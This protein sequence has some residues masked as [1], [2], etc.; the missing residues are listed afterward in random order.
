MKTKSLHLL[1]LKEDTSSHVKE[2]LKEIKKSERT[3]FYFH[4]G[5]TTKNYLKRLAPYLLQTM[6]SKAIL[7][8]KTHVVFIEYDTNPFDFRLL[9]DPFKN[10]FLK[11]LFKFIKEKALNFIAKEEE[12]S[13]ENFNNE[14]IFKENLEEYSDHH[15]LDDFL[16]NNIEDNK[17]TSRGL[18][19]KLKSLIR[20][21]ALK[22]LLLV[23]DKS[24]LIKLFTNYTLRYYYKTDHE[25]KTTTFV[26]ECLK[27][28]VFV[29]L[30]SLANIHWKKVNKSSCDLWNNNQGKSFLKELLKLH[31]LRKGSEIPLK[32]D[33]VSHS[34]GSIPISYLFKKLQDNVVNTTEFINNTIMIVPAVRIKIFQNCVMNNYQI[35]KNLKIYLLD[36]YSEMRDETLKFFK[37]SLLYFVSGVAE[38]VDFIGEM[39]ILGMHRFFKNQS[40]YINEERYNSDVSKF[41]NI[42]RCK[43]F[44][45]NILENRMVFVS[46][47]D[48]VED[49]FGMQVI[50]TNGATHSGTKKPHESPELA[51]KIIHQLTEGILNPEDIDSSLWN[52]KA[53][54]YKI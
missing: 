43:S 38:K 41:G 40:P 3:L 23:K 33:L 18:K 47:L 15:F 20:K 39:T 16:T 22:L 36:D 50:T 29:R 8:D 10:Y 46:T 14:P 52:K 37:A 49:S 17:S 25:N 31:E 44:L 26:E 35:T 2:V 12:K 7:G 6:F 30:S 21:A 19:F 4:G 11:E 45:F 27:I 24:K 54:K 28:K 53:I 51:K 13:I 5:L 9:K 32:I 42:N 48:L 1:N 34:A